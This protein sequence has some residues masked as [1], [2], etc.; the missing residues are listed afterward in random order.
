V[1]LTYVKRKDVVKDGKVN[2][3]YRVRDSHVSPMLRWRML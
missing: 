2:T 3:Q 1:T